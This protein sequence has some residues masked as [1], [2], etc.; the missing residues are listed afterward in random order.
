MKLFITTVLSS[1]AFSVAAQGYVLSP[2]GQPVR[3]G[4]GQ[5][6]RT[7][8]WTPADRNAECDG[9]AETKNVKSVLLSDVLF[10]F[11]KSKLTPEGKTALDR[12]V[13]DIVPGS[14]VSITGHADRIGNAEYNLQLSERRARSVAEYLSTKVNAKYVVRGV[15][16]SDPLPE[17]DSCSNQMKFNQLVACL[18]PNRRVDVVFVK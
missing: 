11:N 5:C 9:L 14:H 1:L 10:G 15:G 2:D 18:S 8:F 3:D 16:S 12:I 7:G 4:S 6:V 13:V 17:T